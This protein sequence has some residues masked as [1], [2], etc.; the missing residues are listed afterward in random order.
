MF[1]PDCICDTLHSKRNKIHGN[2]IINQNS[3]HFITSTVVGWIDVFSREDYRKIIIESLSYCK[4]EKGLIV[5]AF[6]IMSN[7]LHLVVQAKD[8]CQLSNIIR[9]FKKFTSKKIIKTILGNS[10]E[11]RSEWM[12][13]LFK[14]YAKFNSSNNTYQ[15]W[16]QYNKP[17]EL[18]S[19]KWIKQ[20]IDYI[21]LNPVRNG[22]VDSIEDYKYSSAKQYMG[23]EGLLEVELL[24]FGSMQGYIEM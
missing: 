22:L 19:P 23:K 2:K 10:Q 14:Y 3:I 9:D 18:V 15:F 24:D 12:L 16:Q 8:G 20:K 4:E 6:V 11:S 1:V 13:R 21:H 5:Y 17:I 7:H